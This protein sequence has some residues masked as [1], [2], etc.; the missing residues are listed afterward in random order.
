M[1]Q[2]T[3][4]VKEVMDQ[5]R[6]SLML[7]NFASVDENGHSG[8]FQKYTNAIKK[9]DEIVYNLWNKIQNDPYYKD[10]TTLIITT[11]HGRHS[12]GQFTGFKDH[13]ASTREDRHLIF[14]ALGPDIR[15]NY[16]VDTFRQQIDTAPTVGA[17]LGFKTP[18]A[19]GEVM[20]EMLTDPSIAL[21]NQIVKNIKPKLIA[22]TNGLHLLYH[23][24]DTS[25]GGFDIY[26]KRSINEAVLWSPPVLIF[27]STAS[28]RYY[29][30][31]IS[32]D[33]AGKLLATATALTPVDLGGSSYQW[34][35]FSSTSSD[36][37]SS[38]QTVIS[39]RNLGVVTSY[40]VL[41]S[42]SN[43][44]FVGAVIGTGTRYNINKL[45]QF[46]INA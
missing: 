23:V 22:D 33:Y 43:K 27:D 10:K 30:A 18:Y 13:G 24:K 31:D 9:A 34:K 16:T 36:G 17:L 20:S 15:K 29:E 44:D 38:W 46:K 19:D 37:G 26:Y 42:K 39:R 11:D 12:D 3:D 32:T 45:I 6:P 1:L 28:R 40:P 2:L 8:D 25:N 35:L 14:L 7:I 21:N 4:I 41:T 5:N